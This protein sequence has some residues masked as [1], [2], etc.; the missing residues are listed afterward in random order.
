MA[1][2]QKVWE[3]S[4]GRDFWDGVEDEDVS[5]SSKNL[6]SL[7]LQ[8]RSD[9]KDGKT[10]WDDFINVIVNNSEDASDLLGIESSKVS[11]WANKIKKILEEVKNQDKKS[12][13]NMSL[14]GVD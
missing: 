3:S 7:G 5:E 9:R 12:R 10:F 8:I 13:S 11:S 4:V 6:I 2:F 14:T 1:S